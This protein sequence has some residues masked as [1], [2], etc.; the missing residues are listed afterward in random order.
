MGTGTVVFAPSEDEVALAFVFREHGYFL[1]RKFLML[2]STCLA[3]PQHRRLPSA[4]D[5]KQ[6]SLLFI[7]ALA[8]LSK[9]QKLVRQTNATFIFF[10]DKIITCTILP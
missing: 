7:V 10:S 8:R 5:E 1:A 9:K 6:G 2:P 4:P 3:K